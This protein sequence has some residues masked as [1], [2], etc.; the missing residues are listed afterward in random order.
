MQLK[1]GPALAE[2]GGREA[3]G[4]AGARGGSA[5]E[6]AEPVGWAWRGGKKR[7]ERRPGRT[8]L[9]FGFG[10]LFFWFFLPL[11]LSKQHSTNLISNS[12]LNPNPMHSTKIKPCTSMNAQTCLNLEK[13]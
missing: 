6:L 10:F 1:R 11:F 8:G 9:G 12:N 3:R 7:G 4:A 5:G 2:R 13:F